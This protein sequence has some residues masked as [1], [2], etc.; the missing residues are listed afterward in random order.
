MSNWPISEVITAF[1]AAV[2]AW[3][4]GGKWAAR[5]A[6][7]DT[8][9]KLIELWEKANHNCQKE[10]DEMREEIKEV[11]KEAAEERQRLNDEV[12]RLQN[13]IQVLEKHIKNLEAK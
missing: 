11:R 3:F 12:F 13:K 7:V 9:A 5:S 6:K 10:L 8:T 4:S 1:V 2:I